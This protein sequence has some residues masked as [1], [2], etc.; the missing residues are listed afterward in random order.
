[1]NINS[2]ANSAFDMIA[3]SQHK[4]A[5][6]ANQIATFAVQNQEVGSSNYNST[7]LITPVLSLKE[8]E[9]THSAGVKLLDTQQKMLGSII[10]IKA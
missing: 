5:S 6:A 1:M 7:D 9:L 3:A 8:A 4:A 10:D 2:V